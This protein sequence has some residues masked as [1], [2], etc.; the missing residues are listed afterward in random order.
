MGIAKLNIEGYSGSILLSFMIPG[1]PSTFQK[2]FIELKFFLQDNLYLLDL[3]AFATEF[4]ALIFLL[5]DVYI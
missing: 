3:G 1:N 5:Y 2:L 4:L